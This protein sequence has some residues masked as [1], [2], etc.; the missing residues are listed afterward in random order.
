MGHVNVLVMMDGLVS[1]MMVVVVRFDGH[2]R[3]RERKCEGYMR[4]DEYN[5]RET[6]V[7]TMHM[8]NLSRIKTGM[9]NFNSYSLYVVYS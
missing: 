9:S 5:I 8:R 6:Y 4:F 1:V 3:M 7:C 2:V